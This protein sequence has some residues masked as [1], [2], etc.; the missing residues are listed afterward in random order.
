MIIKPRQH[1]IELMQFHKTSKMLGTLAWHGM[2]LGKTLS[3][4]W[5]AREHMASLRKQGIKSPKFL[6]IVPK[7][8]VPTWKVECHTHTPDLLSSMAIYPY[9]QLHNAIK[10]LKYMDIRMLVFDESHYLKSPETNRINSLA[11]FL[12]ELSKVTGKFEQGRILMLTGTPMP[13]SA[14][15]LYTS[16]AICTSPNIEESSKRLRDPIRFDNWKR[17]F[18][19]KK[20]IAFTK[21]RG[22]RKKKMKA[23]KWEG[24][25]NEDKLQQ[26]LGPFV[27][28]KRVEDCIDLPDK[29]EIA[30]DLGLPDDQL[31]AD[32][33]IEEPEAYM[34]LL[35]RLA[36]AKTPYM[37]EWVDDYLHAGE[38][39][40]LVFAQYRFPLEEM[41]E[42]FPKHVRLITGAETA[43]DRAKN[44]ADFKAGQFRIL[45][46]TFKCGS[47]SLNL[48]NAFVSLY[49]GYPW[50]DGAV[51]QAMARTHRSGQSK[52]TLHY[53]LTSG[54]NDQRIL[55]LVR[56]KEE[57]TTKVE[58]MLVQETKLTLNDLI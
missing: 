2:G 1:Q 27:H 34:A 4:L 46:M 8:A 32:A 58:D 51:K 10:S 15:E 3:T 48:Q 26:L 39:Q 35:E 36:R 40:L 5:L 49:H 9:S 23:N 19:K 16:W 7:S 18:S 6:V 45:G 11:D 55:S 20:E 28:Y 38:Q 33:N 43:G 22:L 12:I 30:I 53:F 17:T 21:G 37:M 50:T 31:L 57:A 24:V 54:L 44:L 29:Q 47:E 25:A 41:R 42:K 13:N 14:A 52:K 56:A